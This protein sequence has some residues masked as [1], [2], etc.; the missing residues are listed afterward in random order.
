MTRTECSPPRLAHVIQEINRGVSGVPRPSENE[1]GIGPV[2]L[3]IQQRRK[4]R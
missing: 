4:M 3:G 1:T 2:G